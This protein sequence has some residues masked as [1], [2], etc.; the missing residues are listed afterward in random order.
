MEKILDRNFLEDKEQLDRLGIKAVLFDLD[1]TLIFTSE[2][3]AKYMKEYVEKVAEETGLDS[4]AVDEC[5][6][7]TNDEEYK[8][9]GVNPS[10][11]GAVVIKMA[12]EFDKNGTSV[13]NNLDILMKIY[14]ET[15]RIRPGARAILEGL[16][17]T[18]VKI[19]MVTHANTD[20]TWRKI[21][22]VGIID[23]FDSIHIADENGH[24][25]V[26]DWESI[27]LDLEVSP[28]ECLVIG[29][30]LSGDIIPTAKIGA[31]TVWLDKG[32]TWSMYRTG[33]VPENTLI[34]DE[35]CELLSSMDRL[36]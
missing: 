34:I 1:D 33:E 28:N 27:M 14:S 12:K 4:K 13:I 8:Q 21:S 3:F 29:D 17:R 26:A 15:P 6:R 16:K 11:W 2:I 22:S 23:Y 9:M 35:V 24:K 31:K 5:L 7:R 20:W 10:R 30:S 25:G 32:S 36:R 18:G 19:G